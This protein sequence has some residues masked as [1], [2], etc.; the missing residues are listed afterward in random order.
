MNT[1]DSAS[2]SGGLPTGILSNPMFKFSSNRSHWVSMTTLAAFLCTV[3]ASAVFKAV[4]ALCNT[5][6]YHGFTQSN[7]F[8]FFL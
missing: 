1:Y 2:S 4:I 7:T 6:V 5:W 3:S 8:F